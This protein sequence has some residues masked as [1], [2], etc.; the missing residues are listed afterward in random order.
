MHIDDQGTHP[1][2]PARPPIG[3]H[4]ARVA[5]CAV[6]VATLA[7]VASGVRAAERVRVA[8]VHIRDDEPSRRVR[9]ELAAAGLEAVDVPISSD[10]SRS[11]AAVA[12]SEHA[13]AAVRVVSADE[14]ELA[15]VDTASANVLYDKSVRS[16]GAQSD[17]LALRA[18]EDLRAR[19]VK[20]HLVEPAPSE[21]PAPPEDAPPVTRGAPAH[22][23]GPGAGHGT[24]MRSLWATGA[25]GATASTGGLGGDLAAR[26]GLRV[27]ATPRF[28]GSIAA[29][30]PLL[31]QTVSE[32]G[33][34]ADVNVYVVSALL[35]YALVGSGEWGA[36]LGAG[37]GVVIA[38]MQGFAD[39][40]VYTGR[41]E[42]VVAG[43]P[44][45]DAS[46]SYRP[47]SM[48]RVR[49]EFQAGV[50]MPRLA[51]TFDDRDVAVWGRPFAVALLG[52]EIALSSESDVTVNR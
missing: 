17:S 22:D 24:P 4:A 39:A 42:T 27:D 46:L 49:G 8:V 50:A 44:I 43:A 15:I 48:L 9:A 6:A 1:P 33:A 3:R 18:V 14:V 16:S 26:V 13:V 20:L 21:A 31:S 34:H 29:L 37:A 12:R 41:S 40:P 36:D 35:H 28:G 11:A 23:D 51:V 2:L 38:R 10:D 45:V 32:T 30:L 19:L 52:A 5:R 25:L 7:L 47:I